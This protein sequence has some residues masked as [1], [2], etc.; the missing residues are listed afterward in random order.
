MARDVVVTDLPLFNA[1]LQLPDE[2]RNSV[3]GRIF[4]DG[5]E[6]GTIPRAMIRKKIA[7]VESKPLII[8][9]S[10]MENIRFGRG[11]VD[12]NDVVA[13]CKMIQLHQRIMRLPKQYQTERR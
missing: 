4:L 9:C 12:I 6:L 11:R 2:R 5:Y 10:V 7:L 3:K 13:A 1:L 8:P